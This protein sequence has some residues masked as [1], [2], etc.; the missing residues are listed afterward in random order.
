MRACQKDDIALSAG[1]YSLLRPRGPPGLYA[2]VPDLPTAAFKSKVVAY[3]MSQ[4][5]ESRRSTVRAGQPTHRLTWRMLLLPTVELSSVVRDAHS[6]SDRLPQL[7]HRRQVILRL[8]LP[9]HAR[10]LRFRLPR[11]RWW[12][13]CGRLHQL[14]SGPVSDARLSHPRTILLCC[15]VTASTPPQLPFQPWRLLRIWRVASPPMMTGRLL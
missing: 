11:L 15:L 14:H 10:S 5:W 2:T 3:I 7:L 4:R 6:I 9:P 1:E 8:A 12:P 13:L